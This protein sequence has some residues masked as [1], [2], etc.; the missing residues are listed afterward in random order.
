MAEPNLEIPMALH[1]ID[2]TEFEMDDLANF[3]VDASKETLQQ[4]VSQ[5][6]EK[7]RIAGYQEPAHF[8]EIAALILREQKRR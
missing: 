5:F 1:E 8:M 6:A 7:I 3:S 2:T 4:I